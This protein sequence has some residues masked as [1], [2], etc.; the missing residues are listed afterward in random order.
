[1]S[2]TQLTFKYAVGDPVEL[3]VPDKFNGF[4]YTSTRVVRG[5]IAKLLKKGHNGEPLYD[6]DTAN[7]YYG[8]VLE[9]ALRPV[10][11][12]TVTVYH[13][14]AAGRDWARNERN[15]AVANGEVNRSNIVD[16]FMNG[17]Y[18]RVADI[19]RHGTSGTDEETLQLAY[20]DTQNRDE[21]WEEGRRSTMVGDIFELNGVR[22]MVATVGFERL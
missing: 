12:T 6:V 16:L 8:W 20:V 18:A 1:M 10:K 4:E 13:S 22:Y 2:K 17:V 5:R 11:T 19:T 7:A 14:T 9:S 21:P 15:I 3:D